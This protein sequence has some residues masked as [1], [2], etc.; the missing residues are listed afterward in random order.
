MSEKKLPNYKWIKFHVC[1][2]E[3]RDFMTLDNE[4]AGIYIKL[5][6]LAAKGDSGGLLCNDRKTYKVDDLAWCLRI[7]S[8]PLE[9]S[10]NKLIEK[11]L[12]VHSEEG[13][14]IARFMEEQGPGDDEQRKKWRERQRKSRAR[15]TEE[16]LES[17]EELDKETDTELEK[18]EE[19]EGEKESHGDVTVTFSLAPEFDF[20]LYTS[21]R[22]QLIREYC[23]LLHFS[24]STTEDFVREH[25]PT[26]AFEGRIERDASREDSYT[27]EIALTIANQILEDQDTIY[28]NNTDMLEEIFQKTT[29][30]RI[31][32]EEYKLLWNYSKIV[33]K[34]GSLNL[35]IAISKQFC[36][37]LLPDILQETELENT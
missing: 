22:E 31:T 15:L 6:L 33:Y 32:D 23:R 16:K 10:L 36:E 12:L 7:E 13:Y 3:D 34:F 5:Y 26:N 18:E 29:N 8:E 24:P 9:T 17:D 35:P 4:A 27:S 20:D 21:R 30:R 14:L 19:I 25:L 1:S 28:E 2:M 11:G 37:T